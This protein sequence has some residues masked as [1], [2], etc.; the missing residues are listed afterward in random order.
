MSDAVHV[1]IERKY[2]VDGQASLPRLNGVGGVAQVRYRPPVALEAVYFDT[3]DRDL[4]ASGVTLRR[5]TGGTDAGWHVKIKS[6][7]HRLELQSPLGT[8]DCA[9]VA[10]GPEG[11]RVPDRILDLVQVHVRGKSLGPIA[12]LN[13]LRSVVDL[14]DFHGRQLAEVCDDQVAAMSVGFRSESRVQHWREWEVEVVDADLLDSALKVREVA[15]QGPTPEGASGGE[16]RPAG[17]PAG[18][19][20][21]A[22]AGADGSAAREAP[23]EEP[24][25]GTVRFLDAVGKVLQDSGARPSAAGSK[26]EKV[27]GK[28]ADPLDPQGGDAPEGTTPGLHAVLT[29][30]VRAQMKVLK[31]WDPLVRRD[32]EDSIHQFRVVCR[33]LRST[34]QAYAPLLDPDATAGVNKDL[35]TLGRLLSVAR[36]AEVVRDQVDEKVEDLPGGADGPVAA[37]VP[38][39]TVKRLRKVKADEYAT[40]HDKLLKRMRTQWY[41]DVM[42]R[43][44][45]YARD[46]PLHPEVDEARAA[47]AAG[48]LEPL[49]AEQV[50]AVLEL[51]ERAAAEEDPEHR[52]ELMH[53]VRKEAKRLRYAVKAVQDATGLD[54]GAHLVARMKT[55]KKLQEALGEHRDSIMFQEHVLQTAKKAA[56]AGED[57][58]GYG[59]LFAA[60]FGLQRRTEERASTLV[61]HLAQS[62]GE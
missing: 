33:T 49:A 23:T 14:M 37:R 24:A 20:D 43:L 60:E 52:I 62:H 16:G 22:P 30:T 17:G 46:V 59:V 3:V 11:V 42:D 9:D 50:D 21:G 54:L 25:S 40:A 32:V 1:E 45:A 51:A 57:T 53:E 48:T 56:K 44:D 39:K 27:V 28:A 26:V 5:R 19:G 13:T 36:D 29:K 61:E 4:S 18:A 58:F 41:F 55:A 10:P 35:R 12:R 15:G 47:D 34:L 8:E 38:G 2:D 31:G 6:G 7:E